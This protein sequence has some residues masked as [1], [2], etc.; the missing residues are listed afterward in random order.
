MRRCKLHR[1]SVAALWFQG[2]DSLLVEDSEINDTFALLIRDFSKVLWGQ[3]IMEANVSRLLN[4]THN[5][6]RSEDP[7]ALEG[8]VSNAQIALCRDILVEDSSFSN[9]FGLTGAIIA[10][11]LFCQIIKML[12]TYGVNLMTQLVVMVG[13]LLNLAL[14]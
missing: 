7:L 2:H 8:L 5:N 4:T 14:V 3:F 6:T 12:Y 9:A 10:G 13:C 1:N 11:R